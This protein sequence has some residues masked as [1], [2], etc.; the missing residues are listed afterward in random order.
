M[1]TIVKGKNTVSKLVNSN[2]NIKPYTIE[3]RI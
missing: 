3:V 2:N 1:I